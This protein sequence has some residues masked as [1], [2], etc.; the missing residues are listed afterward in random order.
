M[1]HAQEWDVIQM[2]CVIKTNHLVQCVFARLVTKEMGGSVLVRIYDQPASLIPLRCLR[3]RSL[4]LLLTFYFV[5]FLICLV[6]GFFSLSFVKQTN[7]IHIN[8][9]I[10]YN[11]MRPWK[12]FNS[13]RNNKFDNQLSLFY[14]YC[15]TIHMFLE[16]KCSSTRGASRHV[17]ERV[18]IGHQP[19]AASHP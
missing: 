18:W 5:F 14:A 15:V 3:S 6:R 9:F 16:R 7:N 19:W 11:F 2:P 12:S 10:F 13:N 8:L 4:V 1:A 17:H